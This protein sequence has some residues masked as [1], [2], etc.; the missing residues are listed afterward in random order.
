MIARRTVV[1]LVLGLTWA[2]T[3]RADLTPVSSS[4]SLTAYA[5]VL[6]GSP[7]TSTDTQ[8]QGGTTGPL[9]VSVSASSGTSYNGNP[10]LTVSG[11]ASATWTD[12]SHAE[13]KFTGLGWSGYEANGDAELYQS[14]GWTY[15]FAAPGPGPVAIDYSVTA[16]GWT[17]GPP[18]YLGL[19]GFYVFFGGGTTLPSNLIAKTGINSTGTIDLPVGGGG[20]Y[21]VQIVPFSALFGGVGTTNEQ[22]DGTFD[23][24]AGPKTV[25]VPEMSS[26]TMALS[27]S[28]L[29]AVAIALRRA[30]PVRQPDPSQAPP[31]VYP[32]ERS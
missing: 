14:I 13:V 2:T 17:Y 7:Q 24:Y 8:S 11:D 19:N 9:S 16:S 30:L 27:I 1:L 12:P 29:T 6:Y 4:L 31:D 22:L 3:A 5:S 26:M 32:T 10:W 28:G 23:F 15:T 18:L 20:L 21:T 25:A